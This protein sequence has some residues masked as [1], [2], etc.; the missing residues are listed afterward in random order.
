M[1]IKDYKTG[2]LNS[3]NHDNKTGMQLDPSRFD[4]L[5][6]FA[7]SVSSFARLDH[8]AGSG[9][10]VARCISVNEN[11]L[12][13]LDNIIDPGDDVPDLYT[14]TA[15]LL[16][17]NDVMY[18]QIENFDGIFDPK[19]LFYEEYVVVSPDVRRPIIGEL[20]Y[21]D[22]ENHKARTGPR[23]V[24][25][26]NPITNNIGTPSF[27]SPLFSLF[28]GNSSLG[29][30]APQ[31][32]GIGGGQGSQNPGVQ[33]RNI[34]NP[35]S[36]PSFVRNKEKSIDALHP[37]A[38]PIFQQFNQDLI[39]AGLPFQISETLRTQER[40]NYL[41][42][43][44]R[45]A[46][47]ILSGQRRFGISFSLEIFPPR[48]GPQITWTLSSKHR[49]GMAM[50]YWI[51]P[52]HPYW[53]KNGTRPWTNKEYKGT[54]RGEWDTKSP[55]SRKVWAEFGRIAAKYN[56]DWGGTWAKKD[57][58]HINIRSG[59]ARKWAREIPWPPAR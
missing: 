55:Q 22:F 20:I 31:G 49:T 35:G 56:L 39:R 25:P 19:H 8:F 38:R 48:P 3:L 51:D 18:P 7:A 1:G 47:Q 9:V 54:G 29:A 26:V 46:N 53:R 42:S 5:E 12:G 32:D 58:P 57:Y 50:D 15:A 52:K 34:P 6:K 13:H 24:G 23:Y 10:Q 45:T 43:K 4:P 21:V 37:N 27:L 33:G 36:P 59:Q 44:G 30:K 28:G 40:Q 14:V 16:E 41:F 2:E 17:T 11:R